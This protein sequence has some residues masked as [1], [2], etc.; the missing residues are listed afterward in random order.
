M[1]HRMKKDHAGR[2][3]G[4]KTSRS[5]SKPSRAAAADQPAARSGRGGSSD[6]GAFRETIES[7]VIAFVLAFL[8]R[9]FEAE[10][11]VIPTGSMA[12]TLMG[13]HKDLHCPKCG[14]PLRASASAEV[15]ADTN[16]PSGRKIVECTCP[17]CRYTMNIGE[18]NPQGKTY[19]SYK[20][21][22]I[23]V[24]KFLYQ[25]RDPQRW[26]VA[27]FKWPGGA[28]T[29]FIKRI[30]GLPNETLRI[31]HG[32]IFVKPDGQAEFSIARKP[33]AKMLAMLQPVH[34]SDYELTEL[35]ERGWPSRWAAETPS[36][37]HTT[38]WT[39]DNQRAFRIAGDQAGEH[40]LRYRHVV[41]SYA[42]WS[43]LEAGS[44]PPKL[45]TGQLISDFTAYNTSADSLNQQGPGPD[46]IGLHWVGDLAFEGELGVEDSRGQVVL[47]LVE[48]G[49]RFQCH[50]DLA[51]GTAKLSILGHPEFGTP[52]TQTKIRTPGSYRVMFSNIDDQLRFWVDGQ[53]ME[54][55]RPTTYEPLGNSV[56][57]PA[58][59]RPVGIASDG[60]AITVRHLKV[61][62][63]IHY[64]AERGYDEIVNPNMITDFK[65]SSFPYSRPISGE[66]VAA[67][68]SDPSQ[69]EDF[70]K[71]RSVE[72][73]IEA[74]QFLALGDNS[75][76]SKD[77]RLWERYPGP[78]QQPVEFYVSR[79]LLIGKALFVYWPHSLD[80]IPGTGIP[81]RL[82][83]NFARMRVV[84]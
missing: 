4:R 83:P 30:V 68:L 48:G 22:R 55:D 41:P 46:S 69:W 47:E 5:P 79:N 66:N 53:V 7:I 29:N 52:T 49:E 81:V 84:R 27:V 13:R 26:E 67:V 39:T 76:A 80:R 9:T 56:P 74:G 34:D 71:T 72:F 8:F 16:R 38:P 82:F 15:D 62:R 42:D 14:Y 33:P 59:L 1:S 60:A 44:L 23:L 43:Y 32:D 25:F 45:P 73:K 63:D 6:S 77:G 28:K 65:Y 12:P 11:F 21:D 3:G 31:S 54:F 50:I 35:V 57:T 70:G 75:A 2:A 51:E 58:D 18:N 36:D 20:G 40:W 24:G 78:D 10:A 17:M 19:R 64:I 37:A 61:F